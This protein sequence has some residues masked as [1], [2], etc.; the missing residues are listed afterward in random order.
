MFLLAKPTEWQIQTILAD[1]RARDFS[2][3]DIGSTRGDLPAGYAVL[4][5][6]V[7]LGQGSATF[8]R[9]MNSLLRWKL[10]D[11]PGG[12]LCWPDAPVQAATAVAVLVKHVG[13]WS[14]NCCRIVYVIDDDGVEIYPAGAINGLA[15]L[16]VTFTPEGSR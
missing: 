15:A 8:I 14:I 6:H 4:R 13:F 11:V 1:Q 9:A 3:P 7:D 5:G 16:P 12:R 2:Y 10:F